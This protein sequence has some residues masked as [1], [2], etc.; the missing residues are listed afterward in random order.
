MPSSEP[1][2]SRPSP[3]QPEAIAADLVGLLHENAPADAFA[4]RL[5][6]I[7]AL[8]DG[9]RNKHG[10]IELARMAMSLRHR[11][12]QHEERERGMLA[13]IESAQDL[14][15]RLDLPEL[16]RAIVVR[17]R[18]LLRAHVCWLTIYD[19]QADEFKVVVADGAISEPI[20]RM[21]AQRNRGVAGVV[22][23]TRMPFSTP[24]Y[25]QDARF[26]HDP[27]LDDIFRAEGVSAMVGAP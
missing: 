26:E 20:G 25:L 15:G 9:L 19:E 4:A 22:M 12:E 24:H 21:T 10:L 7:E 13:V 11:L 18:R 17:A 6:S 8:P 1:P 16:L 23:T 3:S 14:A 2:A 27:V 5:A